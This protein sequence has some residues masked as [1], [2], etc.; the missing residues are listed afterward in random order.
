VTIGILGEDPFGDSLSKM[1]LS[2]KRSRRIEDLKS[3]QVI[4]IAK[5]EQPNIGAIIDS[6]G[7]ANVLTV[8][9]TEGFARDGGVIGFT[10]VGDKV[11]FEINTSAARRAG[12]KIDSRLLRLAVRIFNS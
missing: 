11:R 12:L 5:S 7:E 4:F 10:L 3:C 1:H 9:E 6:L 8:G 2:V